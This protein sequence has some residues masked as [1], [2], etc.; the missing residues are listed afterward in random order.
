[1]RVAAVVALALLL[2]APTRV[3]AQEAKGGSAEVFRRYAD[4]V[5]KIQVVETGSGAKSSLGTGFFVSPDGLLLT[6]YH[7]V[8]ETVDQPDRYRAEWSQGGAARPATV[9]AVD[10]INDLAVL[11]TNE[12]SPRFFRLGPTHIAKGA[13]VYSL[14]H[15]EDLGLS[16]VEG[17]YNGNLEH[18]L[19]PKAHF[20]GPLNPG[21]SGG[22]ALTAAGEVVGVNVA[23]EG[24]SVSFLVPIESALPLLA[25]AEAAAGE[26]EG[27]PDLLAA[28]GRQVLE[29]QDRYLAE[30]FRGADSTVR[31]GPFELP[32][33][34]APFFRCWADADRQPDALYDLIDHQCSTDDYVYLSGDQSS[35]IVSLEH[36]VLLSRGLTPLRFYSLYTGEFRRASAEL[37]SGDGTSE[38]R[39][40]DGNVRR[41]R[42]VL[43]VELCVRGYRKLAGLYDAHLKV[44]VLGA[45]DAGLI[46]QLTLSG[47]SFENAE[48]VARHFV[49][50]IRWAKP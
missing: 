6:N 44:A 38:Y 2:A 21:M 37:E 16:I 50:R 30:L 33:Q 41:D 25:R 34:P 13:R 17:T 18:A 4:R 40:H 22:P 19:Y 43:R 49:D 46:T 47:V 1:M 32:T 36:R 35:G 20:T 14:G 7:V 12:P 10:V 15:P 8:A 23:T 28:A 39:C 5:V 45:R 3:A 48:R 11:T 42:M 27:E 29:N 24:N 26:G 9:L 31:L